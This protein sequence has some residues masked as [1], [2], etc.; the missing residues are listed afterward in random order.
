[1]SQMEKVIR[2]FKSQVEANKAD[3]EF[4][5]SLT[6]KQRLDLLS[7]LRARYSPYSDELTQGFKRVCRVVKRK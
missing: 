3:K 4:Y 2:V 6:P 1:M 5:H 7:E